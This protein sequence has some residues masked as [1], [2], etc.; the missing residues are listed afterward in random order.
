MLLLNRRAMKMVWRSLKSHISSCLPSQYKL[1]LYSGFLNLKDTSVEFSKVFCHWHE[2]IVTCVS[3][4]VSCSTSLHFVAKRLTWRLSC[5]FINI[6]FPWEEIPVILTHDAGV[7]CCENCFPVGKFVQSVIHTV[8]RR[9]RSVKSPTH[10][11]HYAPLPHPPA[12]LTSIHVGPLE[13][14]VPQDL[15]EYHWTLHYFCYYNTP[16]CFMI[17]QHK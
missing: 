4:C 17:H 9:A 11:M 3:T 7:S 10:G 8:L 13:A 16:L 2:V 15:G 14:V 6:Y 12:S 1:Q 5:Y